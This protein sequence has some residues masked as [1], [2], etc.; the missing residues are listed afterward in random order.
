M[1]LT[2]TDLSGRSVLLVEDDCF[3][4][5]YLASAIQGA[6]AAVIGPHGSEAD[7][8]AVLGSYDR[9]PSAAVIATHLSQG[10]CT[11]LIEM[12]Q[13]QAIP[14]V[15]TSTRPGYQLPPTW[16]ECE[17][18]AKPYASYQV[19]DAVASLLAAPLRTR[20]SA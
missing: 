1:T 3:T 5:G 2:A 12:L 17:L 9:A 19:V 15:F 8:L 7:A 20:L 13:A 4:A 6:G 11:T 18:L 16:A 14:C 10:F